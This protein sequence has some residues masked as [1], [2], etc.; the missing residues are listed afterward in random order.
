MINFLFKKK[1]TVLDCFTFID[2]LK[3]RFPITESINHIPD[4]FKNASKPPDQEVLDPLYSIRKC[5][6][7]LDLFKKG[8]V[9][10]LPCDVKIGTWHTD[11]IYNVKSYNTLDSEH[12]SL[13]NFTEH[14][15]KLT[16]PWLIKQNTKI[17]FLLTNCHYHSKRMNITIVNGIT[18]FHWIP[19]IH[20]F[21][22]LFKQEGGSEEKPNVTLLEGGYPIIHMIPMEDVQ[23]KVNTHL[24]SQTEFFNKAKT[25]CFFNNNYFK[26]LK[27]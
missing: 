11:N 19:Q 14:F 26:L 4:W 24:I 8:A 17:P 2:V 25:T 27:R 15:H 20:I 5:G 22:H 6:G 23:V 9:L 3:E 7:M 10:P 21:F 12:I 16:I 13:H 18:R 1:T